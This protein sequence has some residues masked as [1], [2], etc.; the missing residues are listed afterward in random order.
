MGDV[1]AMEDLITKKLWE[2]L[3]NLRDDLHDI[4]MKKGINSLGAIRASQ[5]LDIKVNEFYCYQ[6]QNKSH[7]YKL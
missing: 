6:R 7:L 1:L 3:E 4:A 2:E 5:L